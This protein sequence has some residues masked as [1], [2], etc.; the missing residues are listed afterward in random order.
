M[1]EAGIRL[2]ERYEI[3]SHLG[4]G[5]MGEVYRARDLRLGRDVAIKILNEHLA[6]D[7]AALAR[8]DREAKALAA[9]SHPNILAIHDFV[10]TEDISFVV[11]ELLDGATLRKEMAG[12]PVLWGK[13]VEITATIAD[14][15]AAAHSRGIV[16]R[17][18]KPENIFLTSDGG[19]KILDFG[20]ARVATPAPE[21]SQSFAATASFPSDP[22]MIVGTIHYMS[23]EQLRREAVDARSDIFTLGCMLSEMVTATRPFSRNTSAEMIAAILTGTPDLSDIDKKA[24]AEVRQIISHC[25]EK[26]PEARFQSARDLAFALKSVL[27]GSVIAKVPI[28]TP[29][30]QPRRRRSAKRVIDSLAVLPLANV[31]GDADMEYLSDGITE[32]IINSL[33]QL[34]KLRVMARSTVF[35]YKGQDADPQKVGIDLN[36]GAV[37]TGRVILRGD[38]LSI[39]TELV[40]VLDGSQLWG[41]NYRRKSS[42]IFAV[43]EEISQEISEKLRLKL[44]GE[45]KNR[46]AKRHTD[47]TIAYQTYLKGRFHWSKRTGESLKKAIEYFQQ[48]VEEDRDYALA[49]AG[50]ADC[51]NL[52]SAY[53]VLAPDESVPLAKTAALKAVELDNMLAEGHEAL[54]HVKMLYDWDWAGSEAEFKRAMELNPNYATAHQRYAIQLSV[55]DRFQEA[56]TEIRQAQ[57]LDPL[58]L[59][60]NTDVGLILSF[61]ASYDEALEQ[62][63]KTL[64]LDQNFSVAHI[65]CGLALEQKGLYQ[66]AITAFDRGM[67]LS[68]DRTFLS[69][70]AHTYAIWGKKEEAKKLLEELKEIS[71]H[72]YVSPYRMAIV[73]SGLRETDLAFEWLERAYRARSVWLIHLHLKVD[74]R[75]NYLRSDPRFPEL[76]KRLGF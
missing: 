51:Y 9:L 10:I 53:G 37:L 56:M 62:Y 65:A 46:L 29:A 8:F 64:E 34:P 14:G 44:R 45:E 41:E 13:A 55:M 22:G 27:S 11:M 18:L 49:Y 3:L 63:Q 72:R 28:G 16:H 48:A 2:A 67:R 71:K 52:M 42:D 47:N 31:S 6:K 38:A 7:K 19:I 24:P 54:A 32:T 74:P 17:D 35:R 26:N 59:I 76:L 70:P 40:D 20:L 75:L 58:S 66:E 68:G 73:Y 50:L 1:L 43:Q 61:Q 21:A 30:A 33:S 5:G 4:A 57:Q 36:V 25:L 39:Q 60:I 69:S 23:P 12:S 15:L